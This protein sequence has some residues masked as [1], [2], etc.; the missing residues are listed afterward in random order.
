MMKFEVI[1]ENQKLLKVAYDVSLQV[2][3]YCVYSGGS[4]QPDENI[5]CLS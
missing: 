5:E 1:E 4:I 2:F 3:V